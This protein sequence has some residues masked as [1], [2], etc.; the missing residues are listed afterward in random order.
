MNQINDYA[1]IAALVLTICFMSY[2]ILGESVRQAL[3]VNMGISPQMDRNKAH[4]TAWVKT[5]DGG[6]VKRHFLVDKPERLIRPRFFI[7]RD[8]FQQ[9]AKM[10]MYP[11][12][13]EIKVGG[14]HRVYKF[15][16]IR[17]ILIHS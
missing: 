5:V 17:P 3:F 4:G 9:L 12:T 7:V 6:I 10:N 13:L 1:L 11:D 15:G 2:Y 8:M 16:Q 14:V